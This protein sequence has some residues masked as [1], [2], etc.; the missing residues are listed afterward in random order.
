M[1]EQP[2]ASELHSYAMDAL[3]AR[4]AARGVDTRNL[5]RY[6]AI[7]AGMAAMGVRSNKL[8]VEVFDEQVLDRATDDKLDAYCTLRGPVVRH[9]AAKARGVAS[10]TR[11]VATAGAGT[12]LAG[13]E[14]RIP[15]ASTGKSIVAI[16]KTDRAVASTELAA[17]S[18]EI[19]AQQEGEDANVGTVSTGLALTGLP[20]ALWDATL[21]PTSVTLAGGSDVESDE[22]MRERQRLWERARQRCT[23]SAIAFGAKLVNGVKHVVLA[24]IRDPHLG[25]WANIYVGD[26]GWQ[27]TTTLRR[28]VAVSLESW[29]GMG[30]SVNVRGLAQSDV[31]LNAKLRM[32]RPIANYDILA[33]REAGIVAALNFFDKRVDPYQYDATMLAGRLARVHDEVAKVTGTINSIDIASVLAS[34]SSPISPSKFKE[35]GYLP[36]TLTRYRTSR[37]LVTVDVEGPA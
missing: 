15:N 32:A 3:R 17:T 36:S 28:E 5:A 22:D 20:A 33:L 2:R 30:A 8:V 35:L 6:S 12:I 26:V 37:S 4:L 16:V 7:F 13:T 34:V 9:V 29:R 19:E 27:S 1:A 14:I 11:S 21:Q 31:T 25:G 23:L 24:D 18:V 10:F